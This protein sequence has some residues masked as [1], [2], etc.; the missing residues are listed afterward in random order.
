MSRPIFE[1]AAAVQEPRLQDR[2]SN[3]LCYVSMY[4]F[5]HF[6]QLLLFDNA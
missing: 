6:L 3:Q 5:L 2:A 1:R 4:F